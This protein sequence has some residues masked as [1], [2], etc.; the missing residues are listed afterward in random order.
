VGWELLRDNTAI[1]GDERKTWLVGTGE[2]AAVANAG[3]AVS[4]AR[5]YLPR[6]GGTVEVVV[7]ADLGAGV[8]HDVITEWP[9]DHN[10]N[11]WPTCVR[12]P[13]VAG[14]LTT[15]VNGHGTAST[16][17]GANPEFVGEATLTWKTGTSTNVATI[18]VPEIEYIRQ[19]NTAFPNT[20]N[21]ACHMV[22][23]YKTDDNLPATAT[24]DGPAGAS[25]DPDTF[26]VQVKHI[27]GG[28]F[29]K[30]RL[31]VIRAGSSVYLHE[32]AMIAGTVG[33][34]STYRTDQHVRLVSNATDHAHAPADQTPLVKLGDRVKATLVMDR[35][36]LGTKELSVARPSSEAGINA[37]RTATCYFVVVD[38]SDV[39][40]NANVGSTTTRMTEAWAQA[41]AKFTSTHVVKTPVKNVIRVSGAATGP[42]TF[43]VDI[44]GVNIPAFGIAVAGRRDPIQIAEDIAAGI[45]AVLGAG[46]AQ[47]FNTAPGFATPVAHV[48]VKKGQTVAFAN[49]VVTAPGTA[50]SNPAFSIADANIDWQDEEPCLAANFGDGDPNT[51]D[52]F[53]IKTLTTGGRGDAWPVSYCGGS[54][55][56]RN[57][58]FIVLTAGDAAADNP[59]TAAHEAGRFLLNL[60]G[61]Y[62]VPFNLMNVTSPADSINA[63]KRLTPIQHNTSRTVSDGNLLKP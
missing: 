50:I 37:I 38:Y 17:F 20:G 61:P 62:E 59:H 47:A 24:F 7:K 10:N 33:G 54:S 18:T 28:E 13:L 35:S 12:S 8:A 45:N 4:G 63:R 52:F 60:S 55:D 51:M 1:P 11:Q 25:P 41:A 48:V 29:P 53:I 2:V 42:G 57:T 6:G 16:I 40:A 3:V 9:K 14:T 5:A 46:K 49:L 15:V 22:S 32:F 34:V 56:M 23:K 44:D 26:R 19:D 58:S 36:I 30:I 27:Q 39:A 43:T 21:D 31:E